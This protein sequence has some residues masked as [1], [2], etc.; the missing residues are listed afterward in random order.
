M[1]DMNAYIHQLYQYI[2]RQD[3]R[4]SR[5]E[6]MIEELKSEV[7]TLKEKPPINVERLE[8]KFDQLK[9]ERLD[10]TLNIG[11]NPSDLSNIEDM[12]LPTTNGNPKPIVTDP[13][14]KQELMGKLNHYVGNDVHSIIDDTEEQL[15][16][17]LDQHYH[18][19]IVDDLHKQIPQR[20]D[21]YLNVLAGQNHG[22]ISNEEL[23]NQ[24]FL[25]MKA[26]IDQ[27][28]FMFVSKLP[29]NM[30]GVKTNGT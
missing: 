24:V 7:Q 11:L 10:G 29:N 4:I 13:S 19:F 30:N 6:R 25:R 16:T 12:D 8:Y 23:L 9:I 21:H 2:Q 15:G 26:D 14:F 1:V 5:F 3:K 28:V 20:V 27:A 22:N 17:K 18:D